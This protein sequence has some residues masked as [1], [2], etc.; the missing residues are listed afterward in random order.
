MSNSMRPPQT[1]ATRLCRPWDSPGKNIRVGCHFFL[2]CMK[3]KVKS[4]SLRLLKWCITFQLKNPPGI[5]ITL[6][7][8]SPLPQSE[9]CV[10]FSQIPILSCFLSQNHHL[11]SQPLVTL[12]ILRNSELIFEQIRGVSKQCQIRLGKSQSV[13]FK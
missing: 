2:Q 12:G 10:H 8:Q 6:K 1:A 4:L 11:H 9:C 3:V 5:P 13:F 7:I